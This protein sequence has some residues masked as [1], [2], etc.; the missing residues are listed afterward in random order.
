MLVL[1]H[2][3]S[4]NM[5]SGEESFTGVP[6]SHM[7]EKVAAGLQKHLEFCPKDGTIK[8]KDVE[9]RLLIF[10]KC[11]KNSKALQG[12][13]DGSHELHDMIGAFINNM[14]SLEENFQADKL[15]KSERK[16][17]LKNKVVNHL[18]ISEVK[19]KHE[20]TIR[21]EDQISGLVE[22]EVHEEGDSKDGGG[23]IG[24]NKKGGRGRGGEGK[25]GDPDV[26]E[27]FLLSR[28]ESGSSKIQAKKLE[29]EIAKL[30]CESEERIELSRIAANKEVEIRRMDQFT[31]SNN[32]NNLFQMQF[33]SIM[34]TFIGG[35]QKLN[36]EDKLS[37]KKL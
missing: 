18:L 10:Q 34:Q 37:E 36:D 5:L 6:T 35:Q 14:E 1:A 30:K 21:K 27:R 31:A 3:L 22:Y 13:K 9:K 26:F 12:M 20:L 8:K 23:E 33:M 11:F 17:Q 2:A 7:C 25:G 19:K 24:D 28:S 32:Q 4:C 16:K 15:N 29:L